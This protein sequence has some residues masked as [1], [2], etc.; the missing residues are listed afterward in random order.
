[1]RIYLHAEGSD[2]YQ[3]PLVARAVAAMWRAKTLQSMGLPVP[4]VVPFGTKVQ[5]LSSHLAKEEQPSSV[6]APCGQGHSNV[7]SCYGEVRVCS[8][9]R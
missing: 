1:M 5:V 4:G 2:L 8:E 3:W 6:D 7:P 9:N